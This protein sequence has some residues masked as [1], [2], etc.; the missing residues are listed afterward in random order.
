MKHFPECMSCSSK[1]SNLRVNCGNPWS[2]VSWAEVPVSWGPL[3]W[4][5]L[6]WGQSCGTEPSTS[7]VCTNSVSELNFRIPDWCWRIGESMVEQHY[8]NCCKK[9]TAAKKEALSLPK[10]YK[11]WEGPLLTA[12][13]VCH[14]WAQGGRNRVVNQQHKLLWL[15]E[16]K[17]TQNLL[18]DQV[19]VLEYLLCGKL[20]WV[21]SYCHCAHTLGFITKKKDS[22]EHCLA[23]SGWG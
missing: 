10:K 16:G 13:G 8:V 23:R 21:P 12:F 7:G 1:L 20:M 18:L 17:H 3:W 5:A 15:F 2:V 6:K 4:L 9:H 14:C 11:D 19:I 22:L